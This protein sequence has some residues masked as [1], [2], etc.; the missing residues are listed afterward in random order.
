LPQ[1]SAAFSAQLF[2]LTVHLHHVG[3]LSGVL[4]Q[5]FGASDPQLD[6]FFVE[7]GEIGVRRFV[8][9]LVFRTVC[10]PSQGAGG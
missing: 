4:Q 7:A 1:I 9:W 3:M 5:Q 2:E 8:E 6:L 10:G